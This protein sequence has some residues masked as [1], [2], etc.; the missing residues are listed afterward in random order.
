MD[1]F[2]D[3]ATKDSLIDQGALYAASFI[4]IA[5]G[6]DSSVVVNGLNDIDKATKKSHD[7][8]KHHY[9]DVGKADQA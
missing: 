8:K 9:K 6:D 1:A 2:A 5:L 4:D 3:P 7:F